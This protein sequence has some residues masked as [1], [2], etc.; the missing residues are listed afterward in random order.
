MK[1][2]LSLIGILL[3]INSCSQSKKNAKSDSGIKWVTFDELNQLQKKEPKK[4][5]FDVYTDWCGW[6]KVMDKNTFSH[7]K[8]GK[9]VNK[10]FYAVKLNAESY[11]KVLFNGEVLYCADIA[12]KWGVNSYPTT[13]YLDENLNPLTRPIGG[14]LDTTEFNKIVHYFGENAYKTLPYDKYNTPK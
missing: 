1:Y 13:V 8:I 14:Y 2:I 9:Y 7:K 10:N 3:L 5:F 6:C 12:A 4:V 11:E